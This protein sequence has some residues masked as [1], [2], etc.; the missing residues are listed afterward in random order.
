MDSKK[1]HP[2]TTKA[3]L[4]QILNIINITLGTILWIVLLI[5]IGL[6]VLGPLALLRVAVHFSARY[7]RRDLIP[8]TS[9][10]ESLFTFKPY[11]YT[12]AIQV[13]EIHGKLSVSRFRAHFEQVFLSSDELRAK[14]MNLYCGLE[15]WMGYGF[16]KP[17][18]NIM[19]EKRIREMKLSEEE[20][21]NDFRGLDSFIAFWLKAV[22]FE[23]VPHW[24]ITLL[25]IYKN[26][27]G[28]QTILLFRIDHAL[29]DGYT[30]VHLIEKL[31]GIKSPYVVK[32]ELDICWA[33]K[34]ESARRAVEGSL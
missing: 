2:S 1:A 26:N 15:V 9:G 4:S 27:G 21:E 31:S 30:F 32:D 7:F 20:L 18:K 10:L 34:V 14:Y 24:D 22:D 13:W 29:C 3:I 5:P 6:I 8:V 16:K 25:H 19:L 12:C 11:P 28:I 17:V 23:D 33:K